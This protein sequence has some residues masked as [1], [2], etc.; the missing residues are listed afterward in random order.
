MNAADQTPMQEREIL[1]VEGLAKHFRT[2]SALFEAR[3]DAVRAVDGVSFSLA[4]G[5]TL[6]IVGE[7]GS[8]K[9]TLART[10][11]GLQRPTSGRVH[12]MGEEISRLGARQ[13]RRVWRDMQFV[14]QDPYASLDPRMRVAEL[15]GEPLRIHGTLDRAA[16]RAE[17]ARLLDLVGLA[18]DHADRFPHQFSGG[19][20]Q[21][22]GIARALALRPRLV[23]LDEPLSA[24]DVSVQAQIVNLLRDLQRTIGLS[25]VFIAHDLA[26]VH[27]MA[28]KVAVMYLGR[29]VEMGPRERIYRAPT[30]PYTQ[31]LLSAVPIADPA[32]RGSHARI[33]LRGEPPSPAN[34]PSGCRFRT[35]C[36]KAEPICAQQEPPV[37]EVGGVL[38]ACHFA[39]PAQPRQPVSGASD[40]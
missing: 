9:S 10:L 23:V 12:F 3:R 18:P 4:A 29:I 37:K 1:R 21:R 7:S 32:R 27:H 8:G 2:H 24:L 33:I 14:F 34:P 20:R 13:M 35:R 19:Q 36:F 38:S 22:I 17:V 39:A 30:H 15:V 25:Y 11:V 40:A 31:A 6:G 26:T 5:E 28:H 16:R